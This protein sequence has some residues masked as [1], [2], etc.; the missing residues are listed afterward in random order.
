[1]A[2]S[3]RRMN[4]IGKAKEMY[5]LWLMPTGQTRDYLQKLILE[6]SRKYSTPRFEPHVTLSGEIQAP[7]TE[8]RAN[9]VKIATLM[10]PLEIRLR[11]VAYLNQYF[12]CIFIQ[13]EKTK[14]LMRAHKIACTALAQDSDDDYM[15]HLSLMYGDLSRSM[16]QGV[17]QELGKEVAVDFGIKDLHLYYTGGQPKEWYPVFSVRLGY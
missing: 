6:L 11:K 16:K 15:P 17:I 13:A 5:S 1:M 3:R 4:G 9:T 7:I 12:R 2:A 14:A 10:E 8:L